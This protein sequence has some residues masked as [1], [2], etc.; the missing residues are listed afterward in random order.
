M[1]NLIFDSEIKKMSYINIENRFSITNTNK[2]YI[3]K[4]FGTVYC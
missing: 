3:F 1:V 4:A 2:I